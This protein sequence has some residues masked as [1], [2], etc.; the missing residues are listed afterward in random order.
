MSW[1]RIVSHVMVDRQSVRMLSPD[2]LRDVDHKLLD[3]L[4]EGRVTPVYCQRRLED[5]GMEYSRGYLHGRLVRFVEHEHAQNLMETGLYG[6]IEDPRE[7]ND[8]E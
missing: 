6:L 4:N 8:G 5:D 7:E 1:G 2:S 3:Y